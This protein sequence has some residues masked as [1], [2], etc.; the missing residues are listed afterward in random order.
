MDLIAFSFIGILLYLPFLLGGIALLILLI[1][2]LLKM[3]KALGIW[4]EKNKR[5]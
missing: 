3:N 2:V 5:E 1:M 4:L